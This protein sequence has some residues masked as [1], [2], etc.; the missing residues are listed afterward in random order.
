M[1]KPAETAAQSV[2]E[3]A[4]VLRTLDFSV[5]HIDTNI[6]QVLE[7]VRKKSEQYQDVSKYEGDEKQAKN[8]RALLRKQ[9]DATKTTIE[10]IKEAWNRPLDTF[11]TGTKEVL[12]QFDYAIEAIDDWVK[13]GEAREKGKKRQDIQ[14]YFDGK[15]FDL[16]SLDQFFNEKWLN[17]G[18]KMPEIKKEIEATISAIYTNL[19]V[20]EGIAEYGPMVKALYLE[21]LD[22]GAALRQ[23]ETL[24]AN[25]EHLA[26]EQ[27]HRD[28][29][30]RPAQIHSNAADER[31]EEYHAAR[32]ERVQ[33]LAAAALDMEEPENPAA[34]EAPRLIEYTLRFKGTEQQPLR[35]R[36][37]MTAQGITYEKIA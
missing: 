6:D 32:E 14:D 28:E 1:E 8:D 25:A 19:K 13:E 31:R 2:F 10:S 35:L 33:N 22:M 36:E 3:T 27:V 17:K 12:K 23:V 30:E 11:F 9:K 16:V 29:R 20:L 18:T 4:I 26:R 37:Y 21:S 24:K 34:P 15:N 7:V 5:G